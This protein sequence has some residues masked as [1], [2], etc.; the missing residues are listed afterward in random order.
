MRKKC[1][2]IINE[3]DQTPQDCGTVSCGWWSDTHK[4]CAIAAIADNINNEN[5]YSP[6]ELIEA[7]IEGKDFWNG[8]DRSND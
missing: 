6:R 1:P 7:Y 2:L 8:D 3:Y 4:K 5:K